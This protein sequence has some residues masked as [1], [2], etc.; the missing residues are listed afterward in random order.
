MSFNFLNNCNIVK[1]YIIVIVSPKS[2]I[3]TVKQ[4]QTTM[5]TMRSICGPKSKVTDDQIDGLKKGAFTEDR[6]LKCYT[7]CVAQMAGTMK[8]SEISEQKTINQIDNVFPTEWKEDSRKVFENC[9]HIQFNYK[10]LCDKVFY[11]TKCMYEFSPE[12]FRFP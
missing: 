4:M 12:T 7:L 6:D 10:D 3:M 5:E 8:K 2:I 11:S 1:I 9:K